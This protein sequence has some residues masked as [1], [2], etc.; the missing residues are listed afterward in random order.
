MDIIANIDLF[1][2]GIVTAASFILGVVVFLNGRQSQTNRTFFLLVL[3]AVLYGVANYA[4]YKVTDP[5]MTIL[6]LRYVIFFALWYSFFLLHFF[7]I[8][9][10]TSF[11]FPRWYRFGLVPLTMATGILTLT[12]WVFAGLSELPIP[13]S[14]P[15]IVPG[16]AAPLFG[17]MSIVLVVGA[18]ALLVKKILRASGKERV[19]YRPIL[20][21]VVCTF[22]LYLIF[23][24]VLP[25][26]FHELRFI[27]FAALF[28]FPFLACTAYAI[29]KHGLLNIK[30]LSTELLI[31][32]LSIAL[33]FEVITSE[34]VL[35]IFIKGVFLLVLS[36]GILLIGSVRR[37][38][39]EREEV[40]R[41][42]ERLKVANAKLKELDEL[43]TEFLSIASHQLR[44]PLSI[45]KGYTS[46]MEEGAYGKP[47]AEML[48]ILHNID[49]SN[50]R[51]IRLV[52]EFLNVSRIEQGRTQYRFAPMD[53]S[54][55]I[56]SVV[57]ELKEKAVTKQITLEWKAPKEV[58]SITADEDKI[59]HAIYNFVDNAIK[60]SIPGQSNF[61]RAGRWFSRF[62]FWIMGR[63]GQRCSQ[64]LAKV[65]P[66]PM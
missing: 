15:K 17:L 36:V 39:K 60:Y 4:S 62:V 27:P 12:P 32:G 63:P 10:A 31:F 55:T 59:R 50:E 29:M 9:P 37:E 64:S 46:L 41:L 8:F 19:Q 43:K 65:L 5:A 44:T 45:I 34:T 16:P 48:P 22:P 33:L 11:R 66:F 14:I 54:A 47:H 26:A 40:T 61:G 30:V 58:I 51:L 38:V 57:T 7:F 25:L 42:A 23:N 20:L 56:Q 2:V 28:T 1:S 18:I 6:I 52:D 24:M 21:G 49:E 35:T 3:G 53:L 13:N